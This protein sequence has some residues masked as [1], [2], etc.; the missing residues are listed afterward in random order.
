[1]TSQHTHL[2]R[3]FRNNKKDYRIEIKNASVRKVPLLPERTRADGVVVVDDDDAAGVN[4]G[5][6]NFVFK[7]KNDW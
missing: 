4:D 5:D 2:R 1:M 6:A 7:T 3:K